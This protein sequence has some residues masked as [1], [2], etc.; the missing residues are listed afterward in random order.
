MRNDAI[1]L[2]RK[3]GT[4]DGWSDLEFC[5]FSLYDFQPDEGVE[6]KAGDL[7]LDMNTG[8]FE[9]WNHENSEQAIQEGDL[10]NAIK[11]LPCY[12]PGE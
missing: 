5:V 6:I 9:V 2:G 1:V 7:K 4:F 11:H 3:L 8:K 10:L 12:T